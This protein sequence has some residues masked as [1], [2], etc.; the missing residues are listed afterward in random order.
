MEKSQVSI[1]GQG[2]IGKA[3]YKLLF[4]NSR[5]L[6]STFQNI[7]LEC[8]DTAYKNDTIQIKNF[9][10][11]ISFCVSILKSSVLLIFIPNVSAFFNKADI[12]A[13]A[14]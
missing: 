1:I 4:Q 14:Y 11:E 9:D 10:K 12:L 2:I 7:K 5:V 8:Y 13:C 6:K 3:I